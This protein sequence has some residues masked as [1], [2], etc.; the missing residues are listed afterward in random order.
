MSRQQ[1]RHSNVSRSNGAPLVYLQS[2]SSYIAHDLRAV[3]IQRDGACEQV[4]EVVFLF[5]N[6]VVRHCWGRMKID[7][8][9][10]YRGD[11]NRISFSLEWGHEKGQLLIRQELQQLVTSHELARFVRVGC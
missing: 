6:A 2:D 4:P 5:G 8:Y 7:G 9:G 3:W 11:K 10:R 1:C